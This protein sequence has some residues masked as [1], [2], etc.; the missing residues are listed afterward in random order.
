MPA[1]EPLAVFLLAA[2]AAFAQA[3]SGFGFS[4]LIVPPLALVLGPKQAVIVANGLSLCVNVPMTLYLRRFVER[5]IWA[6]LSLGAAAGM[7]LGLLVLVVA[8]PVALQVLIAVMV[9]ASTGLI[10]R[11]LRLRDA[12]WAGYGLTGVISGVL[13]T[14]T[15]MSGPPVVLY[16][17][18]RGIAPNP[19][20]ATLTAFF[21][22]SGVLALGLY[23]AGGKLGASEGAGIAA[24]VPGLALGWVAGNIT[25]NRLDPLRFRRVVVAVLV[26]SALISLAGVAVR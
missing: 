2:L 1:A 6:M 12:G 22:G 26:L 5:R 24:G 23:A 10:V 9:L 20:R 3:V 17:Q 13:N 18:G 4:L 19:F 21:L 15:S 14:S 25:Y 7:P 11:G 8:D 16:L